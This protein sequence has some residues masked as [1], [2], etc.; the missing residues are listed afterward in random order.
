MGTN[1]TCTLIMLLSICKLKYPSRYVHVEVVMSGMIY[2][3]VI[4]AR[5][6]KQCDGL[7]DY[8]D[9]VALM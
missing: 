8:L 3:V 4:I 1:N 6:R 9:S 2:D 7:F 5:L